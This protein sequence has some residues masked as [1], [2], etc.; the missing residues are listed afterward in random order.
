[1]SSFSVAII[2]GG[3]SSRMGTD[4]SFV[5]LLGKPMI[6]HVLE[7]IADLGQS[8]TILIANQPDSYAYL[9]LP[10][11]TDV[12]R[13]KGSLGGIYS[14]L[15]HSETE[16]T[17][18]L[19]CDM[20]FL[21]PDLLRYMAALNAPAQGGPYDVIVPRVDGHPQGLHAF[22]SKNCLEPIRTRL[23]QDRLKVIGFYEQVR[24]RYLD[25]PEYARF[26]AHGLAFHNV[27]TPDEL[28]QAA[29][30]MRGDSPPS[31]PT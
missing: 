23:D 3:K 20:P 13:D 7:R 15:V 9:G 27:N 14:A 30:I 2:A 17:L 29:A 22:Y 21:V 1:M 24:V 18:A 19:A 28:A 31:L 10:V 16:H 8:A 12:L 4:K 25:S 26:D 5:P 11:Y 6:E